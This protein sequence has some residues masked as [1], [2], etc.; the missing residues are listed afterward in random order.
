M[1]GGPSSWGSWTSVWPRCQSRG[2]A[3]APPQAWSYSLGPA[4]TPETTA[5]TK[6]ASASDLAPVPPGS[7]G[8]TLGP[9][10]QLDVGAEAGAD[11]PAFIMVEPSTILTGV[12]E[13]CFSAQ[14]EKSG[15]R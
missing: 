5:S 1:R 13:T 12:L 4:T 14:R 6:G 11:L 15:K 3:P 10:Q 7:P 2:I 8:S 9:G